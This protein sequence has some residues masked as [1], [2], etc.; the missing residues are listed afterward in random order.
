MQRSATHY[1]NFFTSNTGVCVCPSI[2]LL[3]ELVVLA[4]LTGNV[5]LMN[6]K[7]NVGYIITLSSQSQVTFYVTNSILMLR[8]RIYYSYHGLVE[9]HDICAA[10]PAV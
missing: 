9:M 5:Q 1:Y 6:G 4:F 10:A 2:P 7:K 3:L 8:P